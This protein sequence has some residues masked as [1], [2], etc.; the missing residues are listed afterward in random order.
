MSTIYLKTLIFAIQSTNQPTNQLTNQQ[1]NQKPF[2]PKGNNSKK[3]T[4]TNLSL[5][6]TITSH[7]LMKGQRMV[8][9]KLLFTIGFHL[10]V[11]NKKSIEH[12]I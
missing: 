12:K 6:I 5:D 4:R 2:Q 9:V 11:I 7:K 1:T 8:A 10:H 3:I